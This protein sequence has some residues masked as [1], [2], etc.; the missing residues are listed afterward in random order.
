M[1]GEASDWRSRSRWARRGCPDPLDRLT[2]LLGPRAIAMLGPRDLQEIEAGGARFACRGGR[3]VPRRREGA[4]ARRR[5]S[6]RDAIGALAEA[7]PSSGCTSTSTCSGPATSRPP[8][9]CSP[10][11]SAGKNFSRL[12]D[13]PSPPRAVAAAASSSTTRISTPTAMWPGESSASCPRSSSPSRTSRS[14]RR[15]RGRLQCSRRPRRARSARS[16]SCRGKRAATRPTSRCP[17]SAPAGASR[18]RRG[19]RPR[20]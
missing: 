9:T 16:R 4:R 18:S 10:A 20:R 11:D 3:S 15:L 8:T 19:C 14:A 2:P 5:G 7:A 17:A 6:A 13:P 12:R 1:T